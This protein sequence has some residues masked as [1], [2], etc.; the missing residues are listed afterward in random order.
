MDAHAGIPQ[1][2]EPSEPVP[3]RLLNRGWAGVSLS[4]LFINRLCIIWQR[5]VYHHTPEV[6]SA[7]RWLEEPAN[8]LPPLNPSIKGMNPLISGRNRANSG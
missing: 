4:S 2:F 8:T 1:R 7:H 5:A 6:I 3:F